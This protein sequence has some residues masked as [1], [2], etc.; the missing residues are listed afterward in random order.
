MHLV[1][2]LGLCMG[3]FVACAPQTISPPL[4]SSLSSSP[5]SPSASVIKTKPSPSIA[6]SSVNN[7][8]LPRPSPLK[9]YQEWLAE[10]DE[11]DEARKLREYQGPSFP[12][13]VPP[14]LEIFAGSGEDGYQDGVGTEAKLSVLQLCSDRLGNVYFPVYREHVVRKI[15]PDGVAST[16]IGQRGEKGN[17]EGRLTD[18]RLAYPLSCVCDDES[19]LYIHHLSIEP[20]IV[21]EIKKVTP[22]GFV[23]AWVRGPLGRITDMAYDSDRKQI[24]AA[25]SQRVHLISLSGQITHLNG[26]DSPYLY[27]DQGS[28][29]PNYFH[30]RGNDAFVALD[31][32]KIYL[33][34]QNTARSLLHVF[35]E[36]QP[37]RVIMSPL[38]SYFHG[39]G[40]WVH[41]VYGFGQGT[42]TT[43]ID[44]N[45]GIVV[46]PRSGKLLLADRSILS[47][48]TPKENAYADIQPIL[49]PNYIKNREESVFKRLGDL[50]R[51]P[52]GE[53]YLADTGG[54]RIW[55]LTWPET[56]YGKDD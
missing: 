45:A 49:I 36:D 56:A 47:E 8:P 21:T 26:Q 55:K 17:K 54:F 20:G 18:A 12:P 9:S 10:L 16:Y 27:S 31:K 7:S 51:G 39:D 14:K 33:S 34:V 28:L 6:P 40:E 41:K 50:E 44:A 29:N 23:S 25:G 38:L 42:G 35:R 13:P 43:I 48:I 2:K 22:Q 30:Y 11:L 5:V 52:K 19:N 24:V 32:D 4:S 37:F 15:S 53:I 46:S 1:V 3:L